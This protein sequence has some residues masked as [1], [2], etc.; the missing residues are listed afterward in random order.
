MAD[1]RGRHSRAIDAD[2]EG[3][4]REA[5]SEDSRRGDENGEALSASSSTRVR[6]A[7]P[8]AQTARPAAMTWMREKRDT[9]TRPQADDTW[10]RLG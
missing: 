4:E 2:S 10:V 8:V 5:E 6:R 3:A 1:G 7:Q 9:A